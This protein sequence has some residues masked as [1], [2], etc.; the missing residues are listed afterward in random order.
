MTESHHAPIQADGEAN[1]RPGGEVDG[2]LML[3]SA[4]VLTIT[5]AL[6]IGVAYALFAWF[7]DL[8]GDTADK[9]TVTVAGERGP[10][11][12]VLEKTRQPPLEQLT[13]DPPQQTFPYLQPPPEGAGMSDVRPPQG[14][15]SPQEIEA[16]DPS[17]LDK[18]GP[19]EN[20]FQRI[21]IQQAIKV[22]GR[23]DGGLQKQWLPSRA[24]A[25]TTSPLDQPTQSNSGRGPRPAGRK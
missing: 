18:W 5:I 2:R 21:P 17:V 9:Q 16:S 22:L 23:K 3:I 7:E 6:G 10:Q 13:R 11:P 20:G 24:E 12:N 14:V 4:G 8:E 19:P 25:A 15:I 1:G